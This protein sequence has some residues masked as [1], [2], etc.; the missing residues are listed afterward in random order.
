MEI[1]GDSGDHILN[2]YFLEL[3]DWGKEPLPC[4][5]EIAD[6]IGPY[7]INIA[8]LLPLLLKL[9]D[10][11]SSN[12]VCRARMIKCLAENISLPHLIGRTVGRNMARKDL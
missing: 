1:E 9:T 5:S 2:V 3:I 4:L 12:L 11:R 10:T 8:A 6:K 7:S